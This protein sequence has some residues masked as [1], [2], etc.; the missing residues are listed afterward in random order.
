MNARRLAF[1]ALAVCALS[2][3]S[4]PALAADDD[5]WIEK[6]K[7]AK[8]LVK[9]ADP[10]APAAIGSVKIEEKRTKI[11]PEPRPVAPEPVVEEP[12]AKTVEAAPVQETKPLEKPAEAV[13]P[14]EP[15]A[16]GQ[17]P[18]VMP[19]T[20]E[21]DRGALARDLQTP[22]P[23]GAGRPRA[24]LVDTPQFALALRGFG[25][26]LAVPVLGDDALLANGDVGDYRGLR[27]RRLQLGVEGRAGQG[28]TFG[29]WM[30]LAEAPLLLQARLAW[31]FLPELSVE[32]GVIRIPFSRSAI[33]SSAE[34]SFGERPHAVDRLVP[35]RQPGIAI[36]GAFLGGLAS[37]RAGVFNGAAVSRLSLGNDHPGA[38]V[39]GRVAVSPLGPV[40]PGQ[41]DL[42]R[43]PIRVELAA[44]LF[45]DDAASFT[46]RAVGADLL[47]QGLGATLVFEYLADTR[48]PLVEPMLPET[49]TT[50][51][52]R[53]GL[54]GQL[55]YVLPFFGL[56]LAGRFERVDDNSNLQDVG[57]VDG[58]A[59]GLHWHAS[60]DVRVNADWY[61]RTE[62][63]GVPLDNDALVIS[64]QGRF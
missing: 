5:P 30:D 12:A 31:T 8:S 14:P 18:A 48:E 39:A 55:S 15:P 10:S 25:Q 22:S 9:K 42:A 37:Y 50:N 23:G 29:L 54:V 7:S 11:A 62:R 28:L 60:P 44:N 27:V 21:V 3:V 52:E 17:A 41:A 32:A 40:R 56:E 20:P 36:Y 63:F 4:R 51:T 58:L 1:A 26:F 47:V 13:A 57:D 61:G 38:L 6:P 59:L 35:D 49:L 33:Q 19:E 45:Q 46:G 16:T 2:A 24:L 53:S 64:T 43:G 34:L